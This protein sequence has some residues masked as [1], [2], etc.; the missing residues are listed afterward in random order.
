MNLDKIEK[1]YSNNIKEF[2]ID[3]RAVG[4]NTNQT[5]SLRFEKLLQVITD[6]S[7]P[8][9][10]NELGC[11]YGELFKY[12]NENNFNVERFNGYDISKPMLDSCR[13]Y[14]HDNDKITLFNK[15]K[16]ESKADFTITSGIFNV[17]CGNDKESWEKYVKETLENMF[18]FSNKGIA[19]NLLT[20]FVDY[21][22]DNLYYGSP[23]HFFDFCKKKFSNKVTLI[24]DY[25]LYEWTNI[26]FK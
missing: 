7:N 8:F 6:A 15:P 19:F 13:I 14:N 9:S 10:I 2:G 1:L 11:G 3:S 5:Q 17:P 22:A 24:H 12:L 20:S 18:E 4:W 25:D 26:V 21:E 16:I 23:T